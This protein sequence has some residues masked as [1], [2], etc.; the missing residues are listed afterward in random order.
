VARPVLG[1]IAE[2]REVREMADEYEYDEIHGDI[3]SVVARARYEADTNGLNKEQSEMLQDVRLMD[4]FN[5]QAIGEATKMR[6]TALREQASRARA[7]KASGTKTTQAENIDAT[8]FDAQAVVHKDGDGW[9]VR[10]IGNQVG[11]INLTTLTSAAA[12]HRLARKV[13]TLISVIIA[14]FEE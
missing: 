12:A 13:N 7:K 3:L 8:E 6:L 10:V 5:L 9:R 14:T 2:A 1:E 11:R 4:A